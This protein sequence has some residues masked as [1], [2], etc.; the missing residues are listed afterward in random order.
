MRKGIICYLC[1]VL[2][3]ACSGGNGGSGGTQPAPVPAGPDGQPS[4]PNTP[5]VPPPEEVT[6]VRPPPTESELVLYKK[7]KD[8]LSKISLVT[9]VEAGPNLSDAENAKA[10]ALSS[11]FLDCGINLNGSRCNDE[12]GVQGST[13]LLDP[14][15]DTKFISEPQLGSANGMIF[16]YDVQR[17][18][19]LK[20]D[21]ASIYLRL[22]KRQVN[23]D[24]KS[25]MADHQAVRLLLTV[26]LVGYDDTGRPYSRLRETVLQRL[27]PARSLRH[28]HHMSEILSAFTYEEPDTT[29]KING[30]YLSNKKLFATESSLNIA[31]SAM[32]FIQTRSSL[33]PAVRPC[34]EELYKN[35]LQ[36][37]RQYGAV[38]L[39]GLDP[40]QIKFK[41]DALAA[42]EA[43]PNIY[44]RA[45]AIGAL[46]KVS[47]AQS[48]EEQVLKNLS[49]KEMYLRNAALDY[50]RAIHAEKEH[51][52]TLIKIMHSDLSD[53]KIEIAKMI[54][55]NPSKQALY[56]LVAAMDD[57][58]LY[59][60]DTV[61][62][63]L[64]K[65]S[66][67]EADLQYLRPQLSA[68]NSDARIAAAKLAN[69]IAGDQASEALIQNLSDGDLYVRDDLQKLL[70]A[71]DLGEA[72][73][74]GLAKQL[75]SAPEDSKIIAARLLKRIGTAQAISALIN[76][77]DDSSIY[78]RDEVQKVLRDC[79]ISDLYFKLLVKKLKQATNED[80]R[81]TVCD[82]L[83]TIDAFGATAALIESLGDQDLYVRD[84]SQK[85]LS[86]RK[87]GPESV[88][89]LFVALQ[90][91][92][93]DSKI[94]AAQLLGKIGDDF[95]KIALIKRLD[96]NSIYVRDE[97]QKQL[98]KS[99]FS[100]D[101]VDEL[102]VQLKNAAANDARMAAAK[103]LG[104]IKDAKSVAALKK[105]LEKETDIYV[106]DE[107]E[108]AIKKAS[109]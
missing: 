85:I 72:A 69:K 73:A 61:A 11:S 91:T 31:W 90:K 33:K 106:K 101:F 44:I 84:H 103:L 36:P 51:L 81:M 21:S 65:K 107:I 26:K 54:G 78:V 2:L 3:M 35:L 27:F 29:E 14:E 16:K 86:K 70:L 48:E 95:A 94:V 52:E 87:I 104:K 39:I 55:Q 53:S 22:R 102:A 34:A 109:G 60:R 10:D 45:E 17:Q 67:D 108:K 13:T 1:S 20:S 46:S 40:N 12:L 50:A 59:V 105:C 63:I 64:S 80:A 42:A 88:N 57:K 6:P 68:V 32:V 37:L 15:G 96:D 18:P 25:Y 24:L 5:A 8:L 23:E 19:I 98:S 83:N 49:A 66:F 77:V 76:Q 30:F 4:R 89:A 47:L 38:V 79:P 93:E 71:R 43:H 7:T 75:Q 62:K 28:L 56:T 74:E 99:A 9:D 100:V 92:P 82:L 97:I 58:D 41:S